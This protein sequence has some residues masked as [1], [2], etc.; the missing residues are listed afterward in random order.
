MSTWWQDLR[1]ALRSTR[2]QPSVAIL[3]IL[4]M[5]LAIAGNLCVFGMVNAV[6]YRPL[7]FPEAE[8]LVFVGEDPV[9]ERASSVPGV[10]AANF[11]DWQERQTSFETLL[12]FRSQPMN[13]SSNGQVRLLSSAAVAPGFFPLLGATVAQGR[14]FSAEDGRPGQPRVVVSHAFWNREMG[15]ETRLDGQTLSLGGQRVE[16]VGVLAP[17]F[18]FFDPTIEVWAALALVPAEASRVRRDL[19]ALGRLR[20][21]VSQRRA[22]VEMAEIG[23]RLAR[24]H[25]RVNRGLET[26]LVNLRHDVP[27]P[28]NR[29]MIWLLQ[30][31]MA[32]VMAI[33]AVNVA[34]LLLARAEVR[35]REVAVRSALGAPRS[36]IARQLLTE[37]LLLAAA[38]AAV[39]LALGALLLEGVRIALGSALPTFFQ[40]VLDARVVA[41]CLLLALVTTL[42]FGA[43]PLVRSWRWNLADSLR[44][45][46]LGHGGA[47]GR[48]WATRALVVAEIGLAL[49]CLGTAA[50]LLDGFEQLRQ[51]D[52]LFDDADLHLL[53][54]A[55]PEASYADDPALARVGDALAAR[56]AGVPGV[57]GS[58]VLSG[59]PRASRVATAGVHAL[60][61][62]PAD[63]EPGPIATWFSVTPAFFDMADID[64][65]EGRGFEA[66]DRAAAQPVVVVNRSLARRLWPEGDTPGQLTPDQHTSGRFLV[67]QDRERRVV[68]VVDDARHGLLQTDGEL[69]ALYLPWAQAPVRRPT[70]VVRSELDSA[71]LLEPLRVAVGE[72]D[73][74]LAVSNV[75][76]QQVS[77]DRFF[78]SSR[79]FSV[80]LGGFGALALLLAALGTYGVLSYLVTTGTHE[81]GLRMALGADRRQISRHTVR[82]GLGLALLGLA[83]GAPGVWLAT[84]WVR[85]AM[86][87]EVRLAPGTF[88]A[89]VGLLLLV[90]LLASWLPARRA[91][92]LDPARA[93]RRT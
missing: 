79:V 84:R 83:F 24:E 87:S 27:E 1:Y 12:P 88:V 77:V 60:G 61:R 91:S 35:Q 70:V 25:P 13:L 44:L 30:A 8:R 34:S 28:R 43:A 65:L 64:L 3:S 41:F 21:G 52:S 4:S 92:R 46:G 32:F 57:A 29:R 50:L 22:E 36:R 56:L 6:L 73:R 71:A 55:L 31:A 75:E 80:L 42:L 76:R 37:S 81:I 86:L 18:E 39:G 63:G 93:L 68:G 69:E 74:D 15:P 19:F 17:S 20:D 26:R 23:A 40:P 2:Q 67:F 14:L 72:L 48:R 38:C 54:L 82:R 10:S 49:V 78:Q 62:A 11:L 85:S 33:A 90:S 5:G 45:G 51:R 7:P 16:V 9:G 47:G 89:V 53:E 58:A 66:T 59:P